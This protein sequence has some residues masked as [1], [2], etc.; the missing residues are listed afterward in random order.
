MPEDLDYLVF[1]FSTDWFFEYW[2]FLGFNITED[3]RKKLQLSCRNIIDQ[4]MGAARTNGSKSYYHTSLTGKRRKDTE[5][6]FLNALNSC[7][8]AKSYENTSDTKKAYYELENIS[9]LLLGNSFAGSEFPVLD[10]IIK[11]A[12]SHIQDNFE[13]VDLEQYCRESETEWDQ[14]VAIMLDSLLVTYDFI[15]EQIKKHRFPHIWTL[16]KLR[17]TKAQIAQAS[18]WYAEIY[19][20]RTERDLVPTVLL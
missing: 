5:R 3:R 15:S 17:L 13:E 10:P 20:L 6:L 12:I 9:L 2:N 8:C 18:K 16:L 11:D 7:E 19:K 14:S 4:I 1:L